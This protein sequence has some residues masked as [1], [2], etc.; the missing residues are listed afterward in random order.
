MEVSYSQAE[1]E[2]G[3]RLEKPCLVY[4]RDDDVPILPKFVEQDSDKLR[5]LKTWKQALNSNHTVAKFESWPK[6]A[7]QV[8]ADIGNVL[9]V[10][11]TAEAKGVAEA[12]LR[13]VLKRLGETEVAET[14]IPERLAKAADELLRL[15]ADL[16]RFS[17]DRPEFAAIRARAS[18]AIDKGDLNAARAALTEGRERA[19]AL[20]EEANRTEAEFLAQEARVDR[21]QLNYEAACAKFAEAAH[22]D[23]DNFRIWRELGDLWM[24]RG[25]LAEAKTAFFRARDA[26]PQAKEGRALAVIYQRIGGVQRA[27]GDRADALK[28]YRDAQTILAQLAKSDPSNGALR[29]LSVLHSKIGDLQFDLDDIAGALTSYRADL[30][31]A[32]RLAASDP[33]NSG[34]QRD[35][36][37]SYDRI[38]HMKYLQGERESALE[39]FNASL[40]IRERLAKIDPNNQLWQYDFGV[41]YERIGDVQR[42]QR[43]FA[44]ALKSFRAKLSI[45]DR[46]ARSGPGNAGLQRD[47]AASHAKI[48]NALLDLG[49]RQEALDA[50]QRGYALLIPLTTMSPENVDWNEDLGWFA[51]HV[52]DMASE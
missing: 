47:F 52:A 46:L 12:P 15:R 42:D 44:G 40:A 33:D 34:W 13:E 32:E 38:G 43:D 26:A 30:E 29:D 7:V 31:I 2:E 17:N 8:A 49:N 10:K 48:G 50:W 14:E 39:I 5:L 9:L 22:L 37:V 28:T 35:L 11:A 51:K 19:R 21:L 1:Y 45:F 27:Q 24:T 6:L 18:A 16:A 4:L 3:V 25:S 23:P 20:R 41:G 36:S